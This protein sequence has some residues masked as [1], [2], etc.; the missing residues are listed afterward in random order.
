MSTCRPFAPLSYFRIRSKTF[1]FL[2]SLSILLSISSDLEAAGRTTNK[3]NT[4]RSR[5]Q[6][7]EKIAKGVDARVNS[8]MASLASKLDIPPKE[9]TDFIASEKASPNSA[10][11]VWAKLFA[12]SQEAKSGLSQQVLSSYLKV[13]T[14]KTI[15]NLSVREKDILEIQEN[16]TVRQQGNFNLVLARTAEIARSGKEITMES[17]YQR[18]LKE[19]GF[20]KKMNTCKL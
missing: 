8:E 7:D 20:K 12:R 4:I 6:I 19:L 1:T 3:G 10:K 18:A 5:K 14:S 13:R 11:D 15:D 2:A 9:F 17:A 16:W